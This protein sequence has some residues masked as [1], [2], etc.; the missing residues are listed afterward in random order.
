MKSIHV[1]NLVFRCLLEQRD[2]NCEKQVDKFYSS[3]DEYYSSHQI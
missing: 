3:M 1:N 2:E